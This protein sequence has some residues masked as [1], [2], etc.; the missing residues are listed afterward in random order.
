MSTRSTT[1]F[2]EGEKLVAI[3]YRHLDGYPSRTGKDLLEFFKE[4]RD[5]VTDTRFDDASYL[6]AKWCVYLGRKFAPNNPFWPIHYLDFV[7]VGILMADPPDIEYRYIVD[8]TRLD[9]EGYPVVT[10]EDMGQ[11][12]DSPLM[13]AAPVKRSRPLR[14]AIAEDEAVMAR[15][16]FSHQAWLKVRREG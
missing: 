4:V 7:S 5:N 2:K 16:L 15:L 11:V 10:C 13:D 6:A 12:A 3:V 14:E 9:I 8:C 1:H